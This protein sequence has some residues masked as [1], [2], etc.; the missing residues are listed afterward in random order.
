MQL[1]PLAFD[2]LCGCCIVVHSHGCRDITTYIC[3]LNE[4][5]YPLLPVFRLERINYRVDSA[6]IR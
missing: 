2:V 4:T 6:S 1:A 5:P 3:Q